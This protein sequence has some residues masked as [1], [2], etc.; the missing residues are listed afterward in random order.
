[1][2]YILLL[3]ICFSPISIFEYWENISDKKQLELLQSDDI[4][5]NA[6]LFYEGNLIIGD[7]KQTKIL[8][9]SLSDL[10]ENLKLRS[11]YFDLFNKICQKADGALSEIL[12]TYCQNIILLDTEYVLSYLKSHDSLRKEYVQLL[13]MEF[14]FKKNG[15][16]EMQYDF[17]NFK[18]II[19]KKLFND[20]RYRKFLNSFY[21]EI[22]I[23]IDDME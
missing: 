16:S 5:K 12:G 14:Y 13:G 23:A 6:R 1:M 15:T 20:L 7:N 3:F 11:L 8:L 22:Q 18:I 4:C 19:N 2:K 17:S 9:D 10:S 21:K